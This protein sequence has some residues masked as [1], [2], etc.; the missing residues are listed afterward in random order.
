MSPQPAG[1]KNSGGDRSGPPEAVATTRVEIHG[2]SENVVPGTTLGNLLARRGE[3]GAAAVDPVALATVNGCA[4][5]LAQPL[6]GDEEIELIRLHD[7]RAHDAIVRTVCFVLAAA[8]EQLHPNDP[9]WLDFSYGTGI[10]GELRRARPLTAAEVTDLEARMR[11]L[12]ARDLPITPQRYG[13]RSLKRLAGANGL[14]QDFTTLQYVRRDSVTLARMDSIRYLFFGRTLPSTGYLRAFMLRPEPPGFVLQVGL[15]D[16]PERLPEFRQQPKLLAAMREY[17]RWLRHLGIPDVGHLNA[18]IVAGRTA[19]LVQLCEARHNQAIAEIARRVAD[20]PLQRRLVMVAGPSSSGKTSFAKRLALQLR[21]LRL[22]PLVVSL[23]DYFVDR[24]LTP[25]TPDGDYDYET[26]AALRLDL[27]NDHLDRL[28]AGETVRLARFDFATGRSS[29]HEIPTTLTV[30]QPLIVEGIHGLNPALASGIDPDQKLGVYV[31]ALCHLNIDNASYIHTSTT[32]L[33]RR[34]VRDAQF[35]GYTASQTLARWPKV[36]AGEEQH[37][38]PFQNEA[39][40]FFNSGMVYE[41]PVLKLWAEP[42]LAAV[43]PEDPHYITARYLVELLTLLLPIDARQVPPT[44][45]VREFIGES[46]FTY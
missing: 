5:S 12:V 11:E 1:D 38:F 36:R 32:R 44:S 6:W 25:R 15:P 26:L 42:R 23:D 13:L 46:G 8:A 31:S 21:T 7:P 28:F 17:T 19:E 33:F 10:Y 40:V 4:A 16:A 34:I 24:T 37:V 41:L 45:L 18:T 3:P 30:G 39:D 2:E 9:V 29:L 43:P 20:L 27:F 22:Q 35:R 14:N